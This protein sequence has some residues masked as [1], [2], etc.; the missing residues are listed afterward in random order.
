L[1]DAAIVKKAQNNDKQAFRF[2]FSSY[3]QKVY[4]TAYLI[5]KDYQSAEDVVQETFLQVYLKLSKLSDPQAFERWLYRIAVNLC[6]DLMRKRGKTEIVPIDENTDKEIGVSSYNFNGP[7]DAA[8]KK[9]I[10]EKILE[11]INS[12][13]PKH[14][15]VLILFYYNDFSIKEIAEIISSSEGTV[16]S[17]LHHGRK[18]LEEILNK[19]QIGKENK[20][21]GGILYGNQ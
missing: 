7:E 10:Q 18:L 16:K 15:T 4:R 13:T 14:S 6:F 12:L 19:Q 2:I 9:D 3:R 11:S 5:L 1:I 17:R 21:S 20:C 8:I